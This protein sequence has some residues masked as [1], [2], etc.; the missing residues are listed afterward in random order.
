MYNN[1]DYSFVA[2]QEDGTFEY[3]ATQP[4][5]GSRALRRQLKIL[6]D[7]INGFDFIRMSPSGSLVKNGLPEGVTGRA[8]AGSHAIAV[9]VRNTKKDVKPAAALGVELPAGAWEAESIDTKSGQTIR[10]VRVDGGAR[11]ID[12]PP[13]DVDIALRLKRQ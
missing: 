11:T 5:G 9:F 6:A 8:L 4:G 10:T 7:F 13:Y 2:G 1:L 3:P 12:V